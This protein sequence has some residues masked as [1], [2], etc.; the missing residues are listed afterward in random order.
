MNKKLI[1]LADACH[2]MLRIERIRKS[3]Q[4]KKKGTGKQ[5]IKEL[6]KELAGPETQIAISEEVAFLDWYE[7]IISNPQNRLIVSTSPG[8]SR[9]G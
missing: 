2:K 8:R 9:P 7:E 1:I 6:L 4:F 5:K 3:D